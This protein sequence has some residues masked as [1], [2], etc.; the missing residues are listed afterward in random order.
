MSHQERTVVAGILAFLVIFVGFYLHISAKYAVGAYEGPEGLVLMGKTGLAYIGIGIIG[1]I[2]SSILVSIVFAI[3][4]GEKKPSFIV[5]ERD[6]LIEKRGMQISGY[7]SGAGIVS[8]LIALAF[9]KSAL[10]ALILIVMSYVLAEFLS[11][12]A[13]LVMSRTGI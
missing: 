8:G 3:I 4:T 12:V 5:D 10:F 7:L 13:R 11:T 2:I 6:H 9:G 1:V